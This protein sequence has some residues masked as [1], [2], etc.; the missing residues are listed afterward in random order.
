MRSVLVLA[1]SGALL[2]GATSVVG[3]RPLRGRAHDAHID[4]SFDADTPTVIHIVHRRSGRSARFDAPPG[5]RPS[6]RFVVGDNLVVG[7]GCGTSC[8][9]TMLLR[10]DGSHISSYEHLEVS[11]DGRLAA[12]YTPGTPLRSEH[13]SIVSLRTGRAIAERTGVSAWNTC[14]VSWRDRRAFF[15]RCTT[16]TR[17]FEMGVPR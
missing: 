12:A 13:A 10:P 6:V 5:R 15:Q 7:W 1:V 2:F 16:D 11:P 14:H 8:E 17:S 3:A 4:H 9:V